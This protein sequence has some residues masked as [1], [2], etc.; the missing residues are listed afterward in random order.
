M[1]ASVITFVSQDVSL[2]TCL[3]LLSFLHSNWNIKATL[4]QAFKVQ[5]ALPFYIEYCWGTRPDG[6]LVYSSALIVT[7][8]VKKTFT[9]SRMVWNWLIRL[10][11]CICIEEWTVRV[12]SPRLTMWLHA[13]SLLF[14]RLQ[15]LANWKIEN[16]FYR[17]LQATLGSFTTEQRWQL[18]LIPLFKEQITLE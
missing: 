1:H 13:F 10:I 3:F 14:S 11:F 6:V 16:D 18:T 8:V 5:R 12:R 17:Y 9:C 7:L 15:V 2:A 4:C